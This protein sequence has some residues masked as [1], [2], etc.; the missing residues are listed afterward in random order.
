M[1]LVPVRTV[2]MIVPWSSAWMKA[3]S[4]RPSPVSSMV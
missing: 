1:P 3:S 2:S 4:L